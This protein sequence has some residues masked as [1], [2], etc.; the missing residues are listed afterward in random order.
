[1]AYTLTWD[2]VFPPDT[3]PANLLGDDVRDFK[4][5]VRERVASFGA[6][7]LA[8][9]PT[10]ESVFVGVTYFATDTGQYFRWNGASWDEI[11]GFS[12]GATKYTDLNQVTVTNP[13]SPTTGN[14]ITIPAGVI[15]VGSRISIRSRYFT[16]TNNPGSVYLEFNT[17]QI[18]QTPTWASSGVFIAAEAEL[19]VTAA[20]VAR[21]IKSQT[22]I[23]TSILASLTGMNPVSDPSP[24]L[25]SPVLVRSVASTGGAY[26]ITFQG[27]EVEVK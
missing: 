16:T 20:G 15:I 5:D 21:L 26:G 6:G 22:C 23:I 18:T 25:G 8:N 27:L 19:L 3:Q 7:T 1:M 17:L 24:S 2:E 14:Q 12:G 10:P 9:R 11:V 13:P 4:R